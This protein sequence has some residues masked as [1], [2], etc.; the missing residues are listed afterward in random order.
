MSL[1][2]NT[3]LSEYMRKYSKKDAFTDDHRAYILKNLDDIKLL[4]KGQGDIKDT[5]RKIHS[6]TN[7][8]VDIPLTFDSI[9]FFSENGMSKYKNIIIYTHS[10][11]YIYSCLVIGLLAILVALIAMWIRIENEHIQIDWIKTVLAVIIPTM[12][13]SLFPLSNNID[14]HDK[15]KD[16]LS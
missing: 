4:Y 5:I 3:K 14:E 15:I 1:L 7:G 6:V 10:E 8:E 12:V 13:I 11:K 16:D 9:M 2:E